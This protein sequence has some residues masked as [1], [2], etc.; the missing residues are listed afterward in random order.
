MKINRIFIDTNI[1]V[2]ASVANSD[3]YPACSKFLDAH[4]R[5][6]T[7]LV[8]SGQVIREF[9]RTL[10]RPQFCEDESIK[11][12]AL[13]LAE[14]YSRA[15]EVLHE[16]GQVHAHLLKLTRDFGVRGKQVHDA[17]IVATMLAHNVPTLATEN[18]RDFQRYGSL[19]NLINPL[20]L[21]SGSKVQHA[22]I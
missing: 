10:T 6:G 11:A 16:D 13:R 20:E 8:I 9:I 5:D 21:G 19:I 12:E 7:S 4:Q 2:H 3:K 1:L 14:Q 15:Y 17:N 22:P 18:V